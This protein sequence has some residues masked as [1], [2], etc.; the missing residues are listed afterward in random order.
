MRLRHGSKKHTF[1]CTDREPDRK[2]ACNANCQQLFE[3]I[4]MRNST[5]KD[6]CRTKGHGK[7]PTL[8]PCVRCQ[9]SITD[10]VV[11][12]RLRYKYSTKKEGR[13]KPIKTAFLTNY[14]ISKLLHKNRVRVSLR[15]LF[16]HIVS[17][18]IGRSSALSKLELK[19]GGKAAIKQLLSQG[20]S[21]SWRF[22]CDKQ[23][24][25]V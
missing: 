13:K 9:K 16:T 4:K 24:I 6:A 8:T 10:Q 18:P 3:K 25:T 21:M 11:E 23:E 19:E 5:A 14:C 22:T 7:S 15:L 1:K 20:C 17:H 12:C 2:V